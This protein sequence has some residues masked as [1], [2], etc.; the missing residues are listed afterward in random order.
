M[1]R[2]RIIVVALAALACALVGHAQNDV[3]Y[4]M[5]I[6][7]G[8]GASFYLGD[9]NKRPFWHSSAMGAVVWRRVFNPRMVLKAD[10]GF[11]HLGGNTGQRFIPVDAHTAGPEGGEATTLKFS[12]N[13]FDLG[14]QFEF[15]F[16]GYGLGQSYKGYSRLTPYAVLGAGITLAPGGAGTKF[17][18]NLPVGVGVKYKLR[19]R[20]NVGLEW[21]VRFTTIDGL[22]TPKGHTQLDDPY[23]IGS[24][25]FK[26]KDAYS[27]FML[28]LTYDI[29]PKYRKCNN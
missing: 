19:P 15:N 1:R 27:F 11:G 22:D 18:L 24:K 13:V 17:G 9:V 6:G 8:L 3:E 26:N 10:L 7:G 21:T 2:V 23:A 29:S 25:G 5:E 28:S 20:L 12:R 4:R 16:W 14:A